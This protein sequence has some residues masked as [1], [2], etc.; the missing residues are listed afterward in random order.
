MI[1]PPPLFWVTDAKSTQLFSQFRKPIQPSTLSC[2]TI[3]ILP[4]TLANTKKKCKF[5][6]IFL[7]TITMLAWSDYCCLVLVALKD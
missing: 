2:R 1:G 4:I 3:K 5:K 6:S 7:K